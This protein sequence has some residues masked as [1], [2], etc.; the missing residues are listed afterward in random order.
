MHSAG[1]LE[2]GLTCSFEKTILDIDL[3]Q[4]V[5]EFLDP[6]VVDDATLALD[7]VREVGPGGHFFGTSHTQARYREA[8]YAPIL[9]DWRNFESWQEAGSPTAMEKANRVW[10]ECLAAYQAPPIDPEVAEE[11]AAY[12]GRR[13]AEGGF[14]TDF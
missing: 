5:A 12:V 2:G 6:L 9:S 4:M 13:K 8:F 1:W 10:K 7:A 11:L 3:L 14:K